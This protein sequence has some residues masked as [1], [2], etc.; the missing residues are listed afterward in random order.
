MVRR[1]T[2]S[3]FSLSKHDGTNT[4]LSVW[5]TTPTRQDS[6]GAERLERSETPPEN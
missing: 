2:W 3:G 6:E 4:Y 5:T 1:R